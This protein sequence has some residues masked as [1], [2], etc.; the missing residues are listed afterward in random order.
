ME[1]ILQQAVETET[2]FANILSYAKVDPLS[3]LVAQYTA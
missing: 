3:D 1:A 2:D